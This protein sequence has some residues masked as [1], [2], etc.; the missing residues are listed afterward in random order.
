MRRIFSIV[1]WQDFSKLEILGIKIDTEKNN[2]ID[3]LIKISSEDSKIQVYVIPNEE[4]SI[5]LE[6]TLNLV[7]N[8]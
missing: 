6:D 4:D 3:E 2:H 8:G 5:I 1:F 7:R